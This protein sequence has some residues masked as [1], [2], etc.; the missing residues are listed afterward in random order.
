MSHDTL[1]EYWWF[2][3]SVLG[4]LFVMLTFVQGGQTLLYTL[5]PDSRRRDLVVNALG[6]KWELTFT[7]LVT[8]G[9]ALFAAFPLFYATSFGG[10]YWVWIAI[11]L[12]FVLQ[13]VAY[14]YRKKPGNVFGPKTFEI[15]L[16]ING[17]LGVI[18]LGAA[19][20]TLFTGAPFTVDATHLSH[21][22]G[23][24]R[25]LEAA[26][27]PFNVLFGL[28]WFFL[29][30]LLAALYF[31]R[32]VDDDDVRAR[33]VRQVRLNTLLFLPLFLAVA[34]LLLTM[35]GAGYDPAT[36]AVA[37]VPYKY[38]DNLLALPL[39]ALIPLVLGVAGVLYGIARGWRGGEARG[40]FWSAA[41]G[42]ALVG[43]ALFGLAA[44]NDTTLY[45]S[46]ADLQS[47]LTLQN[48]SGSPYTLTVMSYVSLAIPFVLAYIAWVWRQMGRRPLGVDE[49][50]R[51]PMSY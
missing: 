33:S 31:L 41:A 6:R 4:G 35:E 18:L 22:A 28:M 26:L 51:D 10:A 19:V 16:L 5:A 14:E 1:R 37:L 7:T 32:A 45:T 24:A 23:P 12:C 15:F 44:L 43:I 2:L 30:R 42:S 49:V 25:G 21:W 34:A 46:T 38:L 27:V 8:F 9:G 50:E 11:L 29:A 48:A 13:A 40:A 39:R 20:G 47:S 17:S 3:V 36:G